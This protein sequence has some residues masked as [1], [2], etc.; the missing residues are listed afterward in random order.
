MAVALW[1]LVRSATAGPGWRGSAWGAL[2]G[3]VLGALCAESPALCGVAL[4]LAV[5]KAWADRQ[6]TGDCFRHLPPFLLALALGAGGT[7]LLAC[8]GWLGGAEAL[9]ALRM[10]AVESWGAVRPWLSA[11]WLAVGAL[12]VAAPML[13]LMT[14]SLMLCDRCGGRILFVA[15][16]LGVCLAGEALWAPAAL[17]TQALDG[18]PAPLPLCAL[19]AMGQGVLLCGFAAWALR[20]R[21]ESLC[22][23][24]VYRLTAASGWVFGALLCGAR[25]WGAG[26]EVARRARLDAPLGA[27]VAAAFLQEAEGCRLVAGESWL[28][29]FLFRPAGA[30]LLLTRSG[31]GRH[32]GGR[33][34]LGGWRATPRWRAPT[35]GVCGGC[36]RPLGRSFWKTSWPWRRSSAGPRASAA[37]GALFRARLT[38]SPGGLGFA[39]LA[40][41]DPRPDPA[42]ALVRQQALWEAF[43]PRALRAPTRWDARVDAAFRAALR[44][45]FSRMANALGA[46]LE[47]AGRPGEAFDAYRQALARA[48][49]ADPVGAEAVARDFRAFVRDCE[50]GRRRMRTAWARLMEDYGLLRNYELMAQIPTD[51]YGDGF[52]EA[53]HALLRRTSSAPSVRAL[54]VR[55]GLYLRRGEA[56]RAEA[57]YRE[58]LRLGPDALPA[59]RGLAR[60]RL[61]RGD[62]AGALALLEGA[63]GAEAKAVLLADRAACL[64]G[65]GRWDAA[66]GGRGTP[67][68]RPQ[69]PR[70]AGLAAHR[71]AALGGA[72]QGREPGAPSLGGLPLSPCPCLGRAGRRPRQGA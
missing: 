5:V 17:A 40:E 9:A 35:R 34:S 24:G 48:G 41:G 43:G 39:A 19:A 36:R 44:R 37:G 2:F 59:R 31:C 67:A 29:P 14:G 52:S 25:L 8:G 70:R 46:A 21:A 61:A 11:R 10:A 66:R 42:E 64:A 22:G 12:H 56:D 4:P 32:A 49:K 33:P 23:D 60:L 63:K 50:T 53:L 13:M 30:P 27:E 58:A 71:H 47:E 26:E 20:P 65:L 6:R 1:A 55:A 7:F 72:R 38:L 68:H 54:L 28:T 3:V 45:H 18:R 57:C 62:A 15:A 69:R 51:L 16:T